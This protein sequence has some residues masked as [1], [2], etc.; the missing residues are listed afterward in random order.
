MLISKK[1]TNYLSQRVIIS[2]LYMAAGTKHSHKPMSDAKINEQ[3]NNISSSNHDSFED[4]FNFNDRPSGEFG[5]FE[6]VHDDGV[7]DPGSESSNDQIQ[8]VW[9]GVLEK[10]R[11]DFDVK[12]K[13]IKKVGITD[14]KER[15]TSLVKKLQNVPT[16]GESKATSGIKELIPEIETMLNNTHQS[17]D[18]YM[19]DP[20]IKNAMKLV[21]AKK[22][23]VRESQQRVNGCLTKLA[24]LSEKDAKCF[25]E[26]SA[27]TE[28]FS[29]NLN[30][31]MREWI[32]V[33]SALEDALYS[34]IT[35]EPMSI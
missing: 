14:I 7:S 16:A 31:V 18:G 3:S 34:S 35:T 2:P 17:E 27:E 11:L 9:A 1:S 21:L 8:S 10:R 12:L 30:E 5:D 33:G 22:Q 25:S 28:E 23:K 19:Q 20:R 32:T 13:K 26:A 4:T 6:D 29:S 24:K 15:S